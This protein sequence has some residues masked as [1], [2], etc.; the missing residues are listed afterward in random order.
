MCKKLCD[1]RTRVHTSTQR[2]RGEANR[3]HLADQVSDQLFVPHTFTP[4]PK[5]PHQGLF[6]LVQTKQ[7]RC[8]QAP[9]H[10]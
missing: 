4:A 2:H 6:G 3:D 1:F 10:H 9:S 8:E 7:G 5:D